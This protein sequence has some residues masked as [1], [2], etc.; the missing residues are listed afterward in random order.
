MDVEE[1]ETEEESGNGIAYDVR[2]LTTRQLRAVFLATW[3]DTPERFCEQHGLSMS[4]F[5]KWVRGTRESSSASGA[6]HRFLRRSYPSG[7]PL[8][9]LRSGEQVLDNDAS[10]EEEVESDAMESNGMDEQ[11]D[12]FGA[13]DIEP[14]LIVRVLQYSAS[15]ESSGAQ[16]PE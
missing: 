13:T 16:E 11:R 2:D 3:S 4:N 12:Y 8:S 7:V 15:V 6:V 5:L 1:S 10:S 9:V 14:E